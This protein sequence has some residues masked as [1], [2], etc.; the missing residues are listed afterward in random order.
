MNKVEAKRAEK[1][2]CSWSRSSSSDAFYKY[3]NLF[4]NIE[5]QRI[6][7]SLFYYLEFLQNFTI[8]QILFHHFCVLKPRLMSRSIF[9]WYQ[10]ITLSTAF[11]V[12]IP[13]SPLDET[14]CVPAIKSSSLS[15]NNLDCGKK[16][17][18]VSIVFWIGSHNRKGTKSRIKIN[19]IYGEC[20][21]HVKSF[22]L[23][24]QWL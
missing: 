4:S 3:L 16:V 14:C 18:D 12:H 6:C 5:R 11:F 7:Q 2:L 17:G 13:H 1:K 8:N 9:R 19:E 21:E 10:L 20:K 24:P 22:G 23:F 15:Q